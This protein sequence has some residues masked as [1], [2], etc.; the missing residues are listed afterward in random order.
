MLLLFHCDQKIKLFVLSTAA[1]SCASCVTAIANS[2]RPTRH[3]STVELHRVDTGRS[4]QCNYFER[5]QTPADCRRF[6]YHR[7]TSLNS[8][9]GRRDVSG[10]VNG[11]LVPPVVTGQDT[12]CPVVIM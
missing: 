5:L 8:T 4:E 2:P 7:P 1:V 9:V 10:S 6:N 3:N 11:L 12:A